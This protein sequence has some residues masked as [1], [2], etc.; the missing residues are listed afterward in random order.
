MQFIR[1]MVWLWLMGLSMSAQA[2]YSQHPVAEGW[3][4]HMQQQGFDQA[5]LHQILVAATPQ[6]S[7]LAAMNRPIEQ[8]V[9]WG[10]YRD[11]LVS[12][13][14]IRAGVAFW[15]AQAKWLDQAEQQFAVPAAVIVAIIGIETH[16]GRQMGNYRALDALA[17][18]AF[19]YPRR[20]EFFQQ[21]LT[22]LLYFA[23]QDKLDLTD[24]NS[25]YAGAMG[26]GQ[27]IPSSVRQYAVD[28][29]QDGQLDLWQDPADSIGSVANYLAQFGWQADQPAV[30]P[31]T[32]TQP[33]DTLRINTGE[34]PQQ[35]SRE[36]LQQGVAVDQA[37][38][39]LNTP[40]VLL[41]MRSGEHSDYW[42]GFNNYYVITRYNRS[43]LYAMAVLQ[44]SEAI[45]AAYQEAP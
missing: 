45:Q 34:M 37:L 28:F 10:G 32:L 7:I 1:H 42:L 14:R 15:R 23:R 38:F 35:S 12:A 27:F 16:Y 6:P 25:S 30:V 2:D 40:A 29:N 31:V 33:I 26:Y 18:L 11:R 17:T 39:D 24:L 43:R 41:D 36:W 8:R 13:Q 44:L 20:S 22:E 19:D 4:Q 5:Y 9:D 21:Q 3:R